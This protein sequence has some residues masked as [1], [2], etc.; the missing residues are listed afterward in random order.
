MVHPGRGGDF[1]GL[2]LRRDRV[3]VLP[4]LVVGLDRHVLARV[5][6]VLV[7]LLHHALTASVAGRVDA[8]QEAE[9]LHRR[10]GALVV[11]GVDHEGGRDVRALAVVDG[12]FD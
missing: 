9:G 4:R 10:V 12:G 3:G 2:A 7:D 8:V 5:E 1:R 6:D 11:A